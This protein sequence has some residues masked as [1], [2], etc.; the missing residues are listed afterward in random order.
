MYWILW[1]Q[2]KKYKYKIQLLETTAQH[3]MSTVWHVNYIDCLLTYCGPILDNL[4]C[5]QPSKF[6][7]LLATTRTFTNV[8]G[9]NDAAFPLYLTVL[10]TNETA[11]YTEYELTLKFKPLFLLLLC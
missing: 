2:N 6:R 11:Y 5:G 3:G 1:D 4:C 8:L 7:L 9:Q 10:M